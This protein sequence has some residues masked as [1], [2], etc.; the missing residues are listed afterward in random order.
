MEQEL[1]EHEEQ[2]R[3]RRG[4]NSSVAYMEFLNSKKKGT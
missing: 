4:G 3:R 1:K 2:G